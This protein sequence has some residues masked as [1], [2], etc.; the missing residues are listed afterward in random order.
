[1]KFFKSKPAHLKIGQKG[2][3]L[4]LRELQRIGLTVLRTNYT[5]HGIGEIDIIARDGGCLVFVEV[6]TRSRRSFSRAGDAVNREKKKKLWKTAHLFMRELGNTELRFR[7]DVA[8]VYLFGRFKSKI[9][10]L[11]GA[12]NRDDVKKWRKGPVW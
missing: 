2:E 4:A 5:V 9:V 1:M 3:R 11:P 6:K 7:F 8:E 10:Y 12:F